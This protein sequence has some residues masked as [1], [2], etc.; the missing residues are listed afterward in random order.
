[1][2]NDTRTKASR[3]QL[4]GSSSAGYGHAGEFL[5]RIW[6]VL[7]ALAAICAV[8]VGAAV[9]APPESRRERVTKL[10]V[11]IQ[12]ADYEGDRVALGRLYQ[13][14]APFADDKELGAKVRYWRGFAM[15]RRALNGFNDSIDRGE[16]ELDLKQAI[17]EFEVA[18]LMDP[19]FVDPKVGAGSCL[20]NLLFIHQ[21]D[22]ARVQ[23]FLSKA[24]PLLKEAET[25]EPENP[26][27]LWIRGSSRWFQPPETGGGQDKAFE[28]YQKGLKAARD[29]RG[30]VSDP[31]MPSWGE[32]ELLMSL[33]W[34]NL[35]RGTPDLAAAEQYAQSALALVPHWRYVRDILLPQI[36]AAKG[37]EKKL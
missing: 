13:D 4:D 8:Q 20:L 16:L 11:K 34:S 7:P 5:G 31:L 35:N 3:C 25:A 1:M 12:R 27:L 36:E 22:A 15:W 30:L 6:R 2:K 19:A 29:R 28:T 21:K 23:A 37:P 14:L 10:I 18:T 26:R 32:P 24:L 9:G 17:S 33:A